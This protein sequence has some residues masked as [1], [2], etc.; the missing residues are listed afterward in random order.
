MQ[1]E[2]HSRVKKLGEHISY[3]PPLSFIAFCSDISVLCWWLEVSVILDSCSNILVWNDFSVSFTKV[4]QNK[5]GIDDEWK[6][7][8]IY[9]H[10]PP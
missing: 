8:Q 2:H 4:M 3:S 9:V 10:C 6:I 5:T 1:S 7:I